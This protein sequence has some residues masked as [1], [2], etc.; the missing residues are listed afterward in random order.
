MQKVLKYIFFFNIAFGDVIFNDITNSAGLSFSGFSQGVCLFDYNNDG[1]DDILF[2]TRT[3]GTTHLYKNNGNMEFIDVSIESNLS[4]N[5]EARAVIAA[6]YDNDGDQDIFIGATTGTS[7]LFENDGN[8]NFQDVTNLAGIIINDRVSGCSWFDYNQD[9]FL[10]LYIGLV[11]V[12]NLLFK[13]NGDGT[14]VEVA[15]NIGA[16]GPPSGCVI[17]GLGTI[18]YDRDGDQDIFITQDNYNG[19]ILL[20]NGGNGTFFDVSWQSQTNLEVMGMGVAFGDINRDGLFDFYTTNLN[21]N[22]LLLNSASGVFT[23][24]S[25]SSG[26]QDIIGSMGWG[27]FFLMPIMMAG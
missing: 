22:S 26:T 18:D 24:I 5:M 27:T 6:D 21:E 7:R 20:R 12:S 13:N 23:D 10:D 17:M 8:G 19:N 14:F 2:T 11:Y 16:T 1:L 3:G 25:E 9:G 15:Q 4:I